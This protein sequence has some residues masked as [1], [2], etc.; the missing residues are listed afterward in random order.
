MNKKNEHDS[1]FDSAE[2]LDLI[3]NDTLN[4]NGGGK[5]KGTGQS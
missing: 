4:I 1:S 5:R 2:A 3:S